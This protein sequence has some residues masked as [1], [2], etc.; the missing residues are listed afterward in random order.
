MVDTWRGL[1]YWQPDDTS[2][3]AMSAARAHWEDCGCD[4]RIQPPINRFT[5]SVLYPIWRKYAATAGHSR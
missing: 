5:I 1:K 4:T 3:A 2:T